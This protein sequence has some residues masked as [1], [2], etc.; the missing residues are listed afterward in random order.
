MGNICNKS[1][2]KQPDTF[3]E[4]NLTLNS[5]NG[6]IWLNTEPGK[7]FLNT[8]VGIKWLCEGT[9]LTW[10]LKYGGNW[11]ISDDGKNWFKTN[12]KELFKSDNGIY[13]WDDTNGKTLLNSN[14][15]KE[16]LSS[17][18]CIE[19]LKSS[20]GNKWLNTEAV[21]DWI[22]GINSVSSY[23]GGKNWYKNPTIDFWEK[24]YKS[25]KSKSDKSKSVDKFID[26]S[27]SIPNKSIPN[28]SLSRDGVLEWL[29]SDA[30]K[31]WLS[32]DDGIKWFNSITYKIINIEITDI[33]IISDDK[34][35]YRSL[36]GDMAIKNENMNLMPVTNQLAIS[37]PYMFVSI[38]T[39][40]NKFPFAISI[41]CEIIKFK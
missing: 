29:R 20:D 41:P 8:Y 28:K 23:D 13:T 12:G 27:K 1:T 6:F 21:Q 10:L 4:A 9:S 36:F 5:P 15:G 26:W 40:Q 31:M 37:R 22:K 19:F 24:K 25:D 32:S 3:E 39:P 16:W 17:D 11:L 34:K 30:G 33:E 14:N 18:N 38:D 2:F 35:W 7:K